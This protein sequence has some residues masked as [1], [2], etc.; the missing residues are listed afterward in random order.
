[1][2]RPTYAVMILQAITSASHFG[3]SVS[4]QKVKSTI[5]AKHGD[6][7]NHALRGALKKLV[8]AG[9]I[10]QDG[11]RFKILAAGKAALKPKKKV[12]KKKAAPKKKA[13]AKKTA[14]KKTTKKKAAPK[15]KAAKKTAKK[16]T[17]KKKA[18]K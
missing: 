14:K 11:V 15:K 5:E 17:T 4:R 7:T 13:A 12:A 3:K 9:Q 8:E 2:S 6:V 18:K 10:E 1:M 16:K